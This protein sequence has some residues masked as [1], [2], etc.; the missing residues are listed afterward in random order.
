MRFYPLLLALTLAPTAG[1]LTIYR[2]GGDQPPPAL[3]APYEFVQLPWSQAAAAPTGQTRSL[4]LQAGSI[5]PQRLDASTN[6]APSIAANGGRILTI[7]GYGGLA[8]PGG[9]D[10]VLWGGLFNRRENRSHGPLKYWVFDLGGRFTIERVRFYPRQ[11]FRFERFAESFIVGVSDGDSS[12]AGTRALRIA[13]DM[14][15]DLVHDIR[16]NK[17]AAV[18]L[19][20]PAVP[21]RRLLLAVRRNIRSLW[22]IAE[23]EIYASGFADFARYQTAV[24]ALDGALSLGPLAWSGER[25]RDTRIEVRTRLGDDPDPNLYWRSTFRGGEKSL[26]DAAGQPLTRE[27]YAALQLGERAGT[28]HDTQNW[29]H[30]SAPV[31]LAGDAD[32][33]IGDRP[34]RFVQVR[35]DFHSTSRVGARLQFLQFSASPARAAKLAAAIEPT[36]VRPGRT[37]PFTYK[38]LPRFD[39]GEPGFDRVEI[40]TPGRAQSVDAVRIDGRREA[41]VVERLDETG[42]VVEIPRIDVQRTLDLIEIDFSARVFQYGTVFSGRVFDSAQPHEV[43]QSVVAGEADVRGTSATLQVVLTET[44]LNSIGRVQLTSPVCTPNGDGVNDQVRIEYDLLNLTGATP[45]RIGLADLSGRKL[46]TI[47]HTVRSS[48]RYAAVWDG[49]DDGGALLPP[50]VYLL[51]LE[52]ATDRDST[53]ATRVLSLLY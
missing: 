22:E 34:R 11:R 43:P 17:K 25:P 6:L 12:R 10:L 46:R 31:A 35:A 47:E 19:G 13:E 29:S 28:T 42:L 40:D 14:D 23:I 53:P 1:A 18:E 51:H 33:P 49:R 41:F 38:L 9:D 37:T 3:D 45:V 4:A 16:E 44:D 5:A 2:I 24:I 50:G 8:A 27:T 36:Q 15:F 20:F 26:F 30:W 48:G 32:R 7:A 39:G 21:V 52:V